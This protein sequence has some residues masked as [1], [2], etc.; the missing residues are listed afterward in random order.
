MPKTVTL[1]AAANREIAVSN[2]GKILFPEA[3]YT[4]LQLVE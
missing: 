1:I 3:G 4:K 2:P